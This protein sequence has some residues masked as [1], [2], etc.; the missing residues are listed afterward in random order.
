VA[1]RFYVQLVTQMMVLAIF[2]LSLDLLVGFTGL[3]SFGHAAFYG[4]AGYGLAILTRD[5]G[6][7]SIW[8]TLPICLAASG[9]AALAIGWLAIRTSGIYFIMVTL[10]FSQMIYFFFNDARG[11]GGSDGLYVNVKPRMDLAGTVLFD[12]QNRTVLYYA[13]LASLAGAFVFLRVLL[14]SP[15][16]QVINA[17]RINESRTRALGYPIRRY[18]LASFVIAGIVAGLAGYLGAT[19]FGYVNPA[20]IGW[21]ESGKILIVVVLGGTGTLWGPVIGAFAIVLL[22]DTLSAMTE[23]WLLLM[24][25][26]VIGIVLLLP[27]G[28]AGLLLK[29]VDGVSRLAARRQPYRDLP[30]A[31]EATDG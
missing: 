26:I 12:L 18:K 7:T 5:A 9:L 21:R 10:A 19:Q 24:G 13:V 8:L 27:R 1:E 23:H 11:F 3:V 20:H 2:A 6:L 16:G 14:R 15:F 17:I 28:M 22:E 29:L 25:G 30:A 4:L 31:R